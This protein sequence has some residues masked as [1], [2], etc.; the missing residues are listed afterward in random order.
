MKRF[1][2]IC[3]LVIFGLTF[4]CSVIGWKKKTATVT[5]ISG[6][7]EPVQQQLSPKAQ[8]KEKAMK[9]KTSKGFTGFSEEEKNKVT[10]QDKE[11]RW[12]ELCGAKGILSGKNL[13]DGEFGL[14]V[15]KGMIDGISFVDLS[16]NKDLKFSD[17]EFD[18]Q[19][20]KK[21]LFG[22]LKK[23]D[24]SET[25]I[26]EVQNISWPAS[27]KELILA[28]CASLK[29][30]DGLQP[31][32]GLEVLDLTGIIFKAVEEGKISGEKTL[33]FLKL[34][35]PKLRILVLSKSNV[36]SAGIE[37]LPIS[38]VTFDL[39]GCADLKGLPDFKALKN[40]KTLLLGGS[41]ITSIEGGNLPASL[42]EINAVAASGLASITGDLP[43]N[44]K[45]LFA[46]H[47]KLTRIEKLPVKIEFL[48]LS[49]IKEGSFILPDMSMCKGLACVY[50]TESNVT[51]VS[52]KKFPPKA[53]VFDIR[54]S[55]GEAQKGLVRNHSVE[56]I[57]DFAYRGTVGKKVAEEGQEVQAVGSSDLSASGGEHPKSE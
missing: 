34:K 38:V 2:S 14:L 20:L 32:D 3:A 18:F 19:G 45:R 55:G 57:N 15:S 35:T 28:N 6:S 47:T 30:L 43:A 8:A 23:L 46:S 7:A 36:T 10:G 13:T 52:V 44:L 39:R 56:D 1:I 24:L 41:G 49:F 21:K 9:L 53:K 29:S 33:S 51:D 4:E 27:L 5:P 26:T 48:D 40:L 16:K 54:R 42:E 17:P 11:A 31:L 50:L 12:V 25:G 37:K 22:S